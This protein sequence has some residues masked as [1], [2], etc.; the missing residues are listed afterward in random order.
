MSE[1]N[2]AIARRFYDEFWGQGN[3]D[4][5]DEILAPRVRGHALWANPI[6]IV[7][8]APVEEPL[9]VTP[10]S[11]KSAVSVWHETLSDMRVTVNDMIDAGD[12]VITYSTLTGTHLNGRP[13]TVQ[14]LE[15]FR[16]EGGKVV[17]YWQSWDRLGFYQQLG[18]VPTTPELRS[19][20]RADAAR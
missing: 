4:V 17:E 3:L 9:E 1:G 16:I 13:V 2:M 14:A 10:D 7:T 18:V 8:G 12:R 15:V 11:I 20:V 6:D 5:A 19:K